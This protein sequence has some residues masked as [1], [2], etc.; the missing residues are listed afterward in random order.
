MKKITFVDKIRYSFDNMMSKGTVTLIAF[1]GLLALLVI[2][3]LTAVA[4][5]FG[6]TPQ[7]DESINFIN[8]FW[9]SLMRTLD[10]GTMG[11]DAGWP[12]RVLM[13]IV[14]LVG[15]LMISTLIGIVSRGILE[16]VELLRKGRSFVVEKNHILIL[17][18]S[19]KIHTII[20]E[21]VIANENQKN[22][23]IVILAE[24]DK[25]EMEDEIRAKVGK[26]K[27]TKLIFRSGNPI[28]IEDLEIVNPFDTKSIIILDQE[29]ENS[30][31][32]VIKTILAITTHPNRRQGPYHITAEI[33]EPKNLE[34]AK[35][36]GKD[37]VELI[38][39]D[40]FIAL[41]TVQTGR[42]SGLSIVYTELMDFDGDEIYF[43]EEP[44]LV[45]KT[46]GEALFA[47]PDSSV[48]GLQTTD[49]EV[50][51]KPSFDTIIKKGEKIIAISEDDD[52][53][54]ISGNKKY[55]IIKEAIASPVKEHKW[56]PERILILGW[57][58][59][60]SM[61]IKELNN[62][63]INGSLLKIVTDRHSPISQITELAA[64]LVNLKVEF[65]EEDITDR[66]TL[67]NL[68]PTSFDH[69]IL[70]SNHEETSIQQADSKTLMTLLHLRNISQQEDKNI[71][72][73][74][75]MLDIQNRRLAEVTEAD[76]FI[77]SDNIL[78]LLLSQ[79]SENKYLMQVFD[80]LFS[81]K[82]S[83]IYIKPI[84][85]YI[86]PGVSVNYY[87]L[88]ESAKLQDEIAIGYR[89][90]ADK[91]NIEKSHGIVVNPEKS[92]MI[93]FDPEDSVIVISDEDRTR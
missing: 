22:P 84:S 13:L 93:Q 29:T 14:T 72:I 55:G 67:I 53:L 49:G 42:Q 25:I 71:S 20:S 68:D 57:N 3:L 26:T 9:M 70:Q 38:Q 30:D 34:V 78:S 69:I 1:L 43:N 8:S 76:D 75:E 62:C 87:T 31:F 59:R 79:V 46:F 10:P 41:I 2:L 24:K 63:L 48:F 5:I 35:I 40:Y 85:G 45:G 15:I 88:L 18:W 58:Q 82:D 33:K 44:G 89:I 56:Q 17:G 4:V 23:S 19:S 32:Q 47:Y 27:N 80:K 74:S 65:S 6:V 52:T 39:S 66:I 21:L 50:K 64:E 86:S 36:V 11:N 12:F 51:L 7:G 90:Y 61:I 91:T 16:K 73:V 60:S 81:S 37:E 83:G 28:D 92:K 54:I 77:V